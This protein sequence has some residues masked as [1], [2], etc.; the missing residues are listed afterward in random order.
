MLGIYPISTYSP[1]GNTMADQY[2]RFGGPL[3]LFHDLLPA[4]LNPFPRPEGVRGVRLW[5]IKTAQELAAFDNYLNAQFSPDGKYLATL[6]DN[7]EIHLWELPLCKPFWPILIWAVSIWAVAAG[8]IWLLL[9][10]RRRAAAQGAS[11]IEEH[12]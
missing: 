6:H 11:L 8:A 10:L 2:F 12:P 3:L 9:K 5:D 1:D 4:H 7:N